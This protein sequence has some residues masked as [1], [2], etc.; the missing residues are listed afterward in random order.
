MILI[1]IPW[2]T[3]APSQLARICPQKWWR[4]ARP[5]TIVGSVVLVVGC[6]WLEGVIVRSWEQK[7][8]GAARECKEKQE[9]GTWPQSRHCLR[10]PR[11][12]K[13]KAAFHSSS[14][15][16]TTLY[17]STRTSL[18]SSSPLPLF[19]PNFTSMASMVMVTPP[20]PSAS[21]HA[22]ITLESPCCLWFTATWGLS[23]YREAQW[24]SAPLR[25]N[26]IE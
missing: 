4:C 5:V 19:S 16:S 22:I 17:L 13:W 3:W 12:F 21:H 23:G 8:K 11:H 24:P 14:L 20:L 15:S 6:Y 2:G 9:R 18:Q 26:R 7:V 25:W 10:H 1:S